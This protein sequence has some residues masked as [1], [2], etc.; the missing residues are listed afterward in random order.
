M[1]RIPGD[2]RIIRRPHQSQRES[3]FGPKEW[4]RI[5]SRSGE[6]TV[7]IHMDLHH[8]S[9]SSFQFFVRFFGLFPQN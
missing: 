6:R 9:D 1:V 8:L 5:V 4:A 3:L 7:H 2:P